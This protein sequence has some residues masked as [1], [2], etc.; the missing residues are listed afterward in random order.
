MK[1]TGAS[2]F[3]FA[4]PLSPGPSFPFIHIVRSD[5]ALGISDEGIRQIW[6][7]KLAHARLKP[8]LRRKADAL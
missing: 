7:D 1:S 2:I 6:P 4:A 5:L 3:G 8:S